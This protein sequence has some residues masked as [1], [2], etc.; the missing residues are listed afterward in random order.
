MKYLWMSSSTTSEELRFL[1]VIETGI[2]LFLY[3][4]FAAVV[5][6]RVKCSLDLPAY[7]TMGIFL[8][9]EANN[10]IFYLLEYYE[11]SDSDNQ[12]ILF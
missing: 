3:S 2:I 1:S 11:Y 7:I 6:L 4:V 12:R 10:L 8:L 5:L 9:C